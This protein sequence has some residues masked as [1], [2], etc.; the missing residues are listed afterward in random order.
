MLLFLS[1]WP[2]CGAAFYG[3]WFAQYCDFR[4]LDFHENGQGSAEMHALWEKLTPSRGTAFAQRLLKQHPRWVLTAPAQTENLPRL[5]ALREGGFSM[6]F[7]MARAEP[8]SRQRWL[9]QERE[10][11]P[12]V[13]PLDWERQANAI[14]SRARELRPFFRDHCIETLNAGLQL[15]TGNAVAERIGVATTIP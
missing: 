3:E 4:H 9:M 13:R 8:L 2:A 7:L 11:D 14:R 6:W 10:F 5:E 15:M 1:G 12:E